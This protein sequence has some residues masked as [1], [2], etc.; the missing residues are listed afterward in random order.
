MMPLKPLLLSRHRA[1]FTLVELLV[2]SGIFMMLSVLLLSITNQ[3]TTLW[4]RNHQQSQL[5][6]KAR[7]A[8]DFISSEMRQAVLPL[9][10]SSQTGPQFVVNPAGVTAPYRLRDT[11]FWQAPIATSRTSGSLAIVGYFIRNDG[12]RYQLCRFFVNPDD[13]NYRLLSDPADWVND[14]LLE[15]VAPGD[16]SSSYRGLFLENVVGLWV[17]G[18]DEAGSAVTTDSRVLE[19]LPARVKV[20]M[21]VLNEHGALRVAAGEALPDAADSPNAE[22]YLTEVSDSLRPLMDAVQISVTFNDRSQ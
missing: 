21:A 3:A 9:D 14:D 18:F 5:R 4:S 16:E 6:E 12:G 19:R 15:S 10:R 11:V 7:T 2:A 1:A 8:L 13:A 22:A 20:S 17:E